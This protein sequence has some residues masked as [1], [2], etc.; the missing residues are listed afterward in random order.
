MQ[1]AR[2]PV[3]GPLDDKLSSDLIDAFWNSFLHEI[4]A[5]K[6]SAVQ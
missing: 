2:E 3:D 5:L 4:I 1:N 6:S